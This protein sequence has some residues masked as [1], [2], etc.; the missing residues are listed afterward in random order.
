M[1]IRAISLGILIS[2]GMSGQT[3]RVC[4]FKGYV[5]LGGDPPPGPVTIERVCP[6]GAA[7]KVATTDQNGAYGW[8]AISDSMRSWLAKGCIWRAV[9]D[10]YESTV[11]GPDQLWQALRASEQALR[12]PGATI[13]FNLLPELVLLKP[14][15]S[16][17]ESVPRAEAERYRRA[18]EALDG[19]RWAEAEA[20][21]RAILANYPRSAPIWTALGT[22]LQG[23]EKVV[24]ARGAY[25]RA[26]E[27]NARFLQ[28]FVGLT[29]LELAV[30]D[31]EA[32]ARTAAAGIK[33][34]TDGLAPGLHVADAIIR[35]RNKDL[36]GAVI[37]AQR[38]IA[39]DPNHKQPEAEYILGTVLEARRDF[40]AAATH[41][42][43]YLDM[44]PK[45]RDAEAVRARIGRLQSP[46]LHLEDATNRLRAK[47]MSG[48][49]ASAQ[50]ALAQD[51]ERKQPRAEYILAEILEARGEHVLAAA[52]LCRYLDLAP[53]AAEADT[54]RRRI[55][56]LAGN[57]RCGDAAT[58]SD[59]V[60]G[61]SDIVIPGGL[62]ALASMARLD[63]TPSPQDFFLEYCRKLSRI[64]RLATGARGPTWKT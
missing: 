11:I 16:P 48:A 41:F 40:L 2:V 46:V 45:A 64:P 22:A 26:I 55:L 43:A 30:G 18:E 21:F 17:L 19:K 13:A 15:E 50:R 14:N 60:P 62:K 7:S 42:R 59:S 44:T 57:V 37:S 63:R 47:D 31:W 53:N 23:Q 34:D 36:D 35:Q 24:D 20:A 39:L 29:G 4:N 10:G 32:A 6:G 8:A 38:A 27:Y 61:A 12:E 52:H 51:P 58:A 33:A 3:A 49:E 54:V 1:T 28:A 25:Q 56:N 9:L 5:L